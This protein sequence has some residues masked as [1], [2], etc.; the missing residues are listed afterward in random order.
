MVSGSTE[1]PALFSKQI[2]KNYYGRNLHDT[3]RVLCFR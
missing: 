3:G 1:E 2:I